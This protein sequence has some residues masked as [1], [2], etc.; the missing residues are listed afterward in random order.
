MGI[1]VV[2]AEKPSMGRTIAAAL[3]IS[4]SGRSQIAGEVA[5]QRVIITWCIGHLVETAQPEHYGA[6]AWQWK[7]LPILPERFAHEP[8]ASTKEQYDTVRGLLLRPDVDE[9]VNAT[10][11]GREG[12][13]IFHLVY[14]LAGCTKPVLRLWTSSLTEDAIREAWRQLKDDKHWLG[15][16]EAARCRQ[17]ADW[18][19]GINCTRAQTLAAQAQGKEGVYSIGR[20]QTPTLAMLVQREKD[21]RDFKPQDFWK[22]VATF[23][24]PSGE[25]WEGTWFEREPLPAVPAQPAMSAKADKADKAEKAKEPEERDRFEHPAEPEALAKRLQGQPA[26]VQQFSKKDERKK[27]ELLYD[28]TTLQ[29]EA[30]RRL[31]WT[32]EQTLE[33]AQQLYEAG[34]LSYPRTNSRYLT[35]KDAEDAPA[36]LSVLAR[37]PYREVV[38]EIRQMGKGQIPPL[39]GRFVD[40]KEVEDHPAITVTNKS[41]PLRDGQF[42]LP[43]EQQQLYDMVARRLLAAWFP[44]RI[45]RKA[46]LIMSVDDPLEPGRVHTFKSVQTDL[47]DLGWQRIEPPV[48]RPKAKDAADGEEPAQPQTALPLLKKGQKASTEQLRVDKG[49]TSRPRPMT[50]ADLLAGMERAGR[51]LDDEVLRGAMKDCGLGTPATRAAIIETLLQ[52]DYIRRQGRQ[53]R[54]TD[55]GIALIDGISA[56]ALKSPLLTGQWEAAMEEIRRGRAQRP[57]FMTG[58]RDFVRAQVDAIRAGASSAAQASA[59]Q[60]GPLPVGSLPPCP[61]CNSPMRKHNWEGQDFA[62][63]TQLRKPDCLVRWP[64]A[65]D[66]KP[67]LPCGRCDGPMRQ[68]RDGVVRCL[69]CGH[70]PGR[71]STEPEPPL[72]NCPSCRNVM[73]AVWSE[74]KRKWFQFCAVCSGWHDPPQGPL[75]PEPDARPCACGGQRRPRYSAAKH[76]WFLQCG[77]CGGWQW[78]ES[79]GKV[80]G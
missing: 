56:D 39:P 34:L 15:L 80:Q 53:L 47:V 48:G 52:R 31:G 1:R 32:A 40:D 24:L 33:R 22:L 58:I 70:Q 38:E 69:R 3:G 2:V 30:N 29:K 68:Q 66:G 19:V 14:D 74:K 67:Q 23:G 75:P 27:P 17:E 20:V 62:S 18:L 51:Q 45:E 55:K 77:L 13:L 61:E 35:K 11:A 49:Q 12:Q 63:C 9:V 16:T 78:P 43:P 6:K 76:A 60:T 46:T 72:Q 5:G 71:Q 41:P 50:E 21:L 79:Q 10:D 44:D 37:G 7:T 59:R 57:E 4:G 8:V 42:A 25:R 65:P 28:L 64:L 54:A 73:R 26:V 36:W